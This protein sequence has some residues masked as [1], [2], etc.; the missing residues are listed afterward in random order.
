[1]YVPPLKPFEEI[2]IPEGRIAIIAARFHA[3]IVDQL[4]TGAEAALREAGMDPAQWDNYRVPGAFELPL[5]CQAAADNPQVAG[6]IA[7]G[8]VIRGDTPHFDY[9]CNA[10]T[11][12]ILQ[13]QLKTQ[14]PVMFGVLTTDTLEQA[15]NRAGG[16]MGNKGYDAAMALLAMFSTLAQLGKQY[17]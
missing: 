3:E 14:K 15:L 16:E 8:A 10:C 5:A 1:M 13:I 4:V 17:A 7:L 6:V 2:R 9:V 11:D 12:G